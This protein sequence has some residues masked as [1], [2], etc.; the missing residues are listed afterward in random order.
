MRVVC[1]SNVVRLAVKKYMHW[2]S[3][4]GYATSSVLSDYDFR[5]ICVRCALYTEKFEYV[6]DTS[7][8][9]Y[10]SAFMNRINRLRAVKLMERRC[11]RT[12]LNIGNGSLFVKITTLVYAKAINLRETI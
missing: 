2:F 1:T 6:H 9:A 3:L 8:K 12:I 4:C 11:L 7:S 5:V 10:T